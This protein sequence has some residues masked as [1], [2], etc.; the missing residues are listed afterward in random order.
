MGA[1][2]R[3]RRLKKMSP[4]EKSR[5]AGRRYI[6]IGAAPTCRSPRKG[7]R[8]KACVP[9]VSMRT[10]WDVQKKVPCRAARAPLPHDGRSR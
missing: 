1:G 10:R 4:A 8:P 2:P 9:F 7:R 5:F 3:F 6:A